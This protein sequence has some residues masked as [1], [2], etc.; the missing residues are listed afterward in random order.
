MSSIVTRKKNPKQV[1]RGKAIHGREVVFPMSRDVAD[2]GCPV[3]F[4]RALEGR[5][6]SAVL[7]RSKTKPALTAGGSAQFS[8]QGCVIN[9]DLNAAKSARLQISAEFLSRRESATDLP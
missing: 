6:L 1:I 5:R 8:R 2:A 9:I 4:V 7:E 3:H